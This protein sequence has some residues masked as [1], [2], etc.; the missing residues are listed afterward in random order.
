MEIV[1]KKKKLKFFNEQVHPPA[2]TPPAHT[3]RHTYFLRTH[4][5]TQLFFTA[6]L[7]QRMSEFPPV[8]SKVARVVQSLKES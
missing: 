6:P 5:L 7:N 4:V 8:Y 2:P 1:K 3:H